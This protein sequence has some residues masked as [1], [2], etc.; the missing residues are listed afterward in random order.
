VSF[1]VATVRE[2]WAEINDIFLE[3]DGSLPEIFFAKLNVAQIEEGYKLLVSLASQFI[4]GSNYWLAA[5]CR[6]VRVIATDT[7]ESVFAVAD[8]PHFHVV[9][10]GVRTPSGIELP[11]LGVSVDAESLAVDYRMGPDWSPEAVAG[12]MELVDIIAEA[13]DCRNLEHFGNINDPTG[14]RVLELIRACAQR[15]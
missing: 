10:A 2:K 9:L 14:S 11:V 5:E 8:C 12:L 7:V 15:R 13:A 4:S 3:S 6:D 1:M